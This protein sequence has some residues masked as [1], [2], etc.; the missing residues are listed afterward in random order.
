MADKKIT[1]TALGVTAKV[2]PGALDDQDLLDKLEAANAAAYEAEVL[3]DSGAPDAEVAAAE[4]RAGSLGLVA[5]GAVK[6]ALFGSDWER[7]KR[8][9][10]GGDG[11]LTGKR[12][13][14]F[15]DAVSAQIGAL[16]N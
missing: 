5:S 11:R 6:K 2:D 7:I 8:E 10:R 16:K 1:V 4:Q 9:L 12:A 3:R 14:E 15:V 13:N